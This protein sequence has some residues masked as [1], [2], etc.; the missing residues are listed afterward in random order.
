[1]DLHCIIVEEADRRGEALLN[2][3]NILTL[4]RFALIPI[5]IIVFSYGFIISAFF[6]LLLAGL[7]DVL[8][9]YIAR[10]TKQVTQLG[11]MLDP[12]ADKLMMMV[13]VLSLVLIQYIPWEA[14]IAMFIRELS[15]IVSSTVFYLRGKKPVPANF[16]GKMTTVLYFLAI[17]FIVM[18]FNF[19]EAFLWIVIIFAFFTSIMYMFQFKLLNQK[20]S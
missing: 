18:K 5:Y 15:M 17:F 2:V 1:V 20:I 8:D 11:S 7:T 13:A 9:G 16:M 10:K 12:L 6:I 3:P 14:A 19:A 4:C